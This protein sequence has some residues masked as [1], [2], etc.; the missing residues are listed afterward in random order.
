MMKNTYCQGCEIDPNK[1]VN[2][3][4]KWIVGDN[5][6]ENTT[7]H[8]NENGTCFAFRG[9]PERQDRVDLSDVA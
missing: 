8:Y 3:P 4:N 2:L 5:I 9:D 1:R 7:I 6:P